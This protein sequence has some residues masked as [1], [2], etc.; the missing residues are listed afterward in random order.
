MTQFQYSGIVYRN[1]RDYHDAIALDWL[2]SGELTE[3][4]IKST[5]AAQT[6]RFIAEE[7]FDAWEL[8]EKDTS[9][10]GLAAAFGRLRSEYVDRWIDKATFSALQPGD[11]VR[12][13]W[14]GAPG[15]GTVGGHNDKGD[16][17]LVDVERSGRM[18][19]LQTSVRDV[20]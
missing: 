14:L 7:C 20:L 3:A 18:Y 8:S 19:F 16:Q 11:K 15:I 17:L 2:C 9:L 4:D 10:I 6:D 1:S 13:C 12:L 5:F